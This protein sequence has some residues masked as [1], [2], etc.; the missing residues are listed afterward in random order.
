MIVEVKLEKLSGHNKSGVI[1]SIHKKSGDI[2]KVGEEIFDIEAKKGNITITSDVEGEI[3]EIKVKEGDPVSIGDVLLMVEGEKA[4]SKG[5]ANKKQG[6]NYMANFLKPQKESMDSDIVII[7][8]G[9]GG[10]VAAIEGA[11]QGA[12]VILIEKEELGGTCLNRGCIPTKALVR[13][14]EVYELVKN[15]AE[16]GVFN[17]SSSY[18][19]SKIIARK[20]DI[21]NELVGGID[22]LLSKNN[23]TVLKG[24]GEILD[25]NTVFVKEKNKEITINT[26]NIIIATGSKAFVPPIKGAASKNIVTSKEML[27]LSELPQK[28]I[29]VGGGVIGMEFAFICNAL[30]TDVSVVEFAEDILV[31]LD[32]DVR[33]EIREIAIEKGIKIYTS[34]KVEEI[35]DTEEGQSI[36]VFD[37]N[38]TKGYIT[39]DKVLMS[40][41]RVPFYGD[42]DLEKLG[43]DLNEKGRG[44]KVN[45]K[46]Q[47]TVD[48]IYAIGDVTNIIQLAHVASHQGIIAIENIL[49]KDVEANYEVVP[50]AIFT[51]PEIASVGI[52]EKAAM[53]QG[54]SVKTG[55]F[56]FGANGK[57]LT[58]GER[59]GFVKIIT[60]EATGVILGGSIIGPHATDL[61]HE[62]AVAI[63]N[64]LTA[65][66]LINTIH[67]HPTTA[68]AVHEALLATTPKGAIHFAE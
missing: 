65:E 1:G 23:V 43:I 67:A 33:T 27:N 30:D 35:I 40:V 42:I 7:G 61:I 12:K 41:G 6:F 9:P 45:S 49:G 50:S 57:A 56:P 62:V 37:K 31:A 52:H 11:K 13:S 15:S 46:M 19:F 55:K 53:E 64:K 68:E 39:G 20:N 48:N 36:V 51:S 14:S 54:I 34:S 17:S 16:Y 29:I 63:Q 2:V 3:V 5:E 60:E 25:K 44:I 58:Q 22:Y 66:Q 28:I 18:D 32:E 26:N 38:G 4:D 59:R 24:S 10:Y 47:T 8:G 21:V